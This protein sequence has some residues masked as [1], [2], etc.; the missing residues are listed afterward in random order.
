MWGA[1]AFYSETLKIYKDVYDLDV[2][3][4]D[5]GYTF[6]RIPFDFGMMIL[7][8]CVWRLLAFLAMVFLNRDKQR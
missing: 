2:P 1:E 6:D 8:G 3:N 5:Y 7:I 4:S